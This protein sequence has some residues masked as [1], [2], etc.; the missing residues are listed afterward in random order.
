VSEKSYSAIE[1]VAGIASHGQFQVRHSGCRIAQQ[2]RAHAAVVKRVG[3]V[4]ANGRAGCNGFV[5]G[6]AS[7][8]QLAFIH[9]KIAELLPVSRGRIVVNLDE[10]L[11]DA[12]AAGKGLEGLPQKPKIG[13]RLDTKID[14][15]ARRAEEQDDENPI[16]VR[17]AADEVDDG[18]CLKQ[19]APRVEQRTKDRLRGYAH[20]WRLSIAQ[21]ARRPLLADLALRCRRRMKW[22]MAAA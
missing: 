5:E 8:L 17:P 21:G 1:V 10:Q 11:G 13:Q 20:E 12:L 2:D 19:Q 7:Q 15:R 4:R 3:N 18:G 16:G 14:Q 9:I 22:T 6:I